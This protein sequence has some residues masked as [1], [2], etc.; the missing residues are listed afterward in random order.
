[1]STSVSATNLSATPGHDEKS[2]SPATEQTNAPLF[3]A[4]EIER[5]RAD[6]AAA[7]ETLG[8]I[9]SSGFVY[10]AIASGAAGFWTMWHHNES[11]STFVVL[12]AILIIIACIVSGWGKAMMDYGKEHDD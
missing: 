3:T 5:F 8:R 12:P 4:A 2:A 6:D 7:G 1:M 11:L 9:L 10:T